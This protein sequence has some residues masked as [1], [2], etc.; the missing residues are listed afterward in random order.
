MLKSMSLMRSRRFA[1]LAAV[2]WMTVCVQLGSNSLHAQTPAA[3]L[4]GVVNSTEEGAM[5]GVLVSAQKT[6]SSITITVVSDEQG[7]FNF[8]ATKLGRGQYSLRIRAIGYELEEAQS[9]DVAPQKATTVNLRLRKTKDLAAQLSNA[10]WLES[11]PGTEAEKN[12]L[13]GCT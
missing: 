8:P 4:T 2:G 7:R 13:L 3:A 5:E 11:A 9:A 10:E 1:L 6:G 12:V